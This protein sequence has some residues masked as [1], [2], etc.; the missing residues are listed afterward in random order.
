MDDPLRVLRAVRFARRFD[1]QI[2]EEI[3]IAARDAR[4]R[5]AFETKIT[6]ERITKEMDKMLSNREPHVCIQQ[7]HDF[8]VTSLCIKPPTE[9]HLNVQ[10]LLDK[11]V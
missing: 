8:G 7:M 10:E 2:C 4:V 5:E 1:L 6:Y 3:F 11:S 9:I